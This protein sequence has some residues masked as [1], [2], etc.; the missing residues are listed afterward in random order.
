MQEATTTRQTRVLIG[1]AMARGRTAREAVDLFAAAT[2]AA[3]DAFDAD[4]ARYGLDE[5]G[6]YRFEKD[7][8]VYALL[9]LA[10]EIEDRL[11]ELAEQRR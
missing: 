5:D 6:Y 11:Y 7:S 1:E 4:T 9:Q 10:T 8:G 2:V 3:L